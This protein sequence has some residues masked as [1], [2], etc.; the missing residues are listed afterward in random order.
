MSTA[1]SA[2]NPTR[3]G[4]VIC[5]KNGYKQVTPKEAAYTKYEEY[6]SKYPE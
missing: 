2:S 6:L 1:K 3:K 4:V 5:E